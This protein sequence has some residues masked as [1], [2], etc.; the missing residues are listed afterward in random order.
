MCAVL[1]S[2]FIAIFIEWHC[3]A[4]QLNYCVIM[5]YE[6]VKWEILG[7][8]RCP[9]NN[10]RCAPH[11]TPEYFLTQNYRLFSQRNIKMFEERNAVVIDCGSFTCKA[12]FVA[13]NSPQV[14]LRSV[15][16]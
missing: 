14:V 8:R 5:I 13:H 4:C 12:G 6:C 15:V 11:R 10:R 3:G 1:F 2:L 16:G 7:N 9:I